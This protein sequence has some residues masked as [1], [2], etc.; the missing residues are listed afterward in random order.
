M[1]TRSYIAD[2]ANFRGIRVGHLKL[3]VAYTHPI[4]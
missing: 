3:I 1:A 4:L 2:E